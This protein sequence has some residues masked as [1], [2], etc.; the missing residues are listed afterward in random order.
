MWR[1]KPSKYKNA[2]PKIPKKREGWIT[3]ISVGSL[4]SFGNHIKASA[5]YIAFNIDSGGGGN[6]GILT[7]N[8][9]G[10]KSRNLP[11]LHA[12]S[13][14]ITDFDFCPYDDGILATGSQD[15][16]VK[17]WRITD[18]SLKSNIPCNPEVDILC[19]CKVEVL[20]F[21]PQADCILSVA[22]DNCI[23]LWDINTKQNIYD[24]M[25]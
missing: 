5:A 13:E 9:S 6:L 11:V 25:C 8:D 7:L 21:H 3:D 14:F 19:Q 22:E 16:H 18:E 1:F 23:R 20:K 12:H 2:V 4:P 15:Q 24:G 17:L 10:S